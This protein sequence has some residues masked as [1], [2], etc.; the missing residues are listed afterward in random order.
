VEYGGDSQLQ[1]GELRDNHFCQTDAVERS[2]IFFFN[3]CEADAFESGLNTFQL[4]MISP[5]ILLP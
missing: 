5:I 3:E 2:L 4:E 1:A